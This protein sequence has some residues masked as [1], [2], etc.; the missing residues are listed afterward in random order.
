MCRKTAHLLLSP[1]SQ[2]FSEFTS[3]LSLHYRYRS[4]MYQNI[5]YIYFQ[6]SPTEAGMANCQP[7]ILWLSNFL[8]FVVI[9]AA[10]FL[11]PTGKHN[12]HRYL[13]TQLSH[14]YTVHK[15]RHK[16]VVLFFC[17]VFTQKVTQKTQAGGVSLHSSADLLVSSADRKNLRQ[18][19]TTH[20]LVGRIMDFKMMGTNSKIKR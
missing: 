12:P 19:E 3:H 7:N 18:V 15:T 17:F 9:P 10:F 20:S 16:L 14:T 1:S 4:N 2:G 5:S 8:F 13:C 6:L 11:P